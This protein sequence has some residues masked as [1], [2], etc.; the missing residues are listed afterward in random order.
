MQ[1][2]CNLITRVSANLCS[3]LP[4]KCVLVAS[5]INGSRGDSRYERFV[6][7]FRRSEACGNREIARSVSC[8]QCVVADSYLAQGC[9]ARSLESC[10]FVFFASSDRLDHPSNSCSLCATKF[11]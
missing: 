8:Y 1:L 9:V 7:R 3:P 5:V 2:C 11:P 6:R 4:D 10:R